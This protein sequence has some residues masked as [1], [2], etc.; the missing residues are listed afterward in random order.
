[1]NNLRQV[2]EQQASCD[3]I[4]DGK[5]SSPYQY[6]QH[7]SSPAIK[8][9][10]RKTQVRQGS[11][12]DLLPPKWGRQNQSPIVIRRYAYVGLCSQQ[13][14]S[15]LKMQ[16]CTVSAGHSCRQHHIA[17]IPCVFIVNFT[18]LSK[19][20]TSPSPWNSKVATPTFQPQ[21]HLLPRNE[22]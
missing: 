22:F 15:Q 20:M 11:T 16:T 21:E 3:A 1:M 18:V 12:T 4:R 8:Q 6:S 13:P 7:S 5:P 14:Q 9:F 19:P 10:E 17:G 2:S